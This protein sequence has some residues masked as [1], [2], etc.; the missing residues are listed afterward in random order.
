VVVRGWIT[1]GYEDSA[2]IAGDWK[3]DKIGDPRGIGP[4]SGT[5]KLVGSFYEGKLIIELNPEF[6][7]NNLQLIG[8]LQ[9]GKYRGEWI[10]ISFVGIT[11]RGT[12]EAVKP[13]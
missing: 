3:L 8:D 13:L 9:Q 5:G 1:I 12:F 2:H 10:W 7:D 6:R 4:Q 11:G